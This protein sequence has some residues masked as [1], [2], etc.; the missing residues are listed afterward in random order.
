[1]QIFQVLDKDKDGMFSTLDVEQL[2]EDDSVGIETCLH[3]FHNSNRVILSSNIL[4][5]RIFKKVGVCIQ[6]PL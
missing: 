6:V 3:A 4:I 5:I 1:M 2:A